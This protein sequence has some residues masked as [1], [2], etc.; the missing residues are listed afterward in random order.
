MKE[1]AVCLPSLSHSLLMGTLRTSATIA[2]TPMRAEWSPLLYRPLLLSDSVKTLRCAPGTP[3]W[4]SKPL[5]SLKRKAALLLLCAIC[6]QFVREILWDLCFGEEKK[7]HSISLLPNQRCE[8][9]S[10]LTKTFS[11]FWEKWFGGQ[12]YKQWGDRAVNVLLI[13]SAGICRGETSG[14]GVSK[15]LSS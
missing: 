3:S 5:Q 15:C 11:E 13:G 4:I 1:S 2:L 10:P 14:G 12:G 6:S 7:E 8:R 9:N